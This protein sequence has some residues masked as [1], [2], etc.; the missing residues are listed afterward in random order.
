MSTSFLI[1]F[2]NRRVFLIRKMG[3]NVKTKIWKWI[4]TGAV[5]WAFAIIFAPVIAPLVI[6]P[7]VAQG[8]IDAAALD[9]LRSTLLPAGIAGWPQHAADPVTC[10]AS[11]EGGYYFNTGTSLF[12]TCDGTTWANREGAAALG[13][14]SD[15]VITSVADGQVLQY[16]GVTDNRWENVATS[17]TAMNDL[18][19]VEAPAPTDGQILAYDGVTDNRWELSSA[20]AAAL[21]GLTDTVITA[22]ADREVLRFDGADWVDEKE[23]ANT[24]Y[25]L[26]PWQHADSST[27][28]TVVDA[29]IGAD[30]QVRVYC[31]VFDH[32]INLDRI[33]WR[34]DADGAG[35]DFGA[36][37]IYSQDGNTLIFDSGPV[38]YST[39]NTVITADP[40]NV[41]LDSG[42]YYVAYTADDNT[43]TV[44]AF[45]DNESTDDAIEL[46]LQELDTGS[47]CARSGT[48]AN[49]STA[50]Q[51]PTT[52]GTITFN[53]D[54]NRPIIVFEGADPP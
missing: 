51:L 34:L 53:L 17:A 29:V 8:F 19:D 1:S 24:P 3:C 41:Y 21:S 4:K 14:L 37:G 45:N 44:N 16:D 18:T 38:A 23:H 20:S 12:K 15:V 40:T 27:Q 32:P 10:D 50:G 52:T 26:F 47:N 25:E 33:I 48:A 46:L 11:A 49:Q 9:I 42:T 54:I 36:V 35:C 31:H 5:V 6:R 30:A 22:A 2:A 43:C 13:D 39:A 28:T 7:A